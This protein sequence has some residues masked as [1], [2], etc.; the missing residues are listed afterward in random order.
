MVR[1]LRAFLDNRRGSVAITSALLM[2][3]LIGFTALGVDAGSIYTDRRK[4]QSVA[5]LAALAAVE[6]LTN[7]NTAAAATIASNKLTNSSY[8]LQ[9]GVYTPDPA[10]APANRFV[11]SSAAAANA[12]RIVLNTSTPLFFARVITGRDNFAI[13]T[14]ATAAQSSFAAFAIGSRLLT[15][16][17][18]LLNSVL[19]SLL[20]TSLSLS[21]MDYNAL[22][23]AKL[24]AFTF[25][26]ALATRLQVTSGTYDS[27]LSSNVKV[28]DIVSAM[29]DT[30]KGQYGALSPAVVALT[31]VQQS[32]QGITSK[33]NIRTMID[34][35]PYD[36]MAVG[37][38]PQASASLAAY[39]MLAAMAELA[40][41]ASQVAVA[42][43]V[44]VPGIAAATLKIKI[45]ERPQGTSWVTFG[46]TGATVHTAQTRVLLTVQLAGTGSYSLV[47]VPIYIEIA[48][49]TATLTGISCGFPDIATSTATLGVTPGLIDAWIGDVSS[50][51]FKNTSRAPNPGAAT[52]VNVAG[53]QVTARAHVSIS[54]MTATPVTFSYSDIQNQTKKTVGTTSYASS[55]VSHLIGDTT[56]GV[57][58]FGFG[59]SA[60]LISSGVRS[61]L[62]ASTTPIDQL[63][64][65][66]LQTLGVGLGQADVWMSGIRCDGGVLVL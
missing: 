3:A 66:T 4:A 62:V 43:N 47:S 29:T 6:N 52:I 19:G 18:G 46:S 56:L 55:L 5:D 65:S 54:N 9:F 25:V 42:L 16:D 23:S 7:G 63:L 12:A 28:G 32:I 10:V 44:S 20:G 37:T 11:P 48:S 50:S 24:D 61:V 45:G 38:R 31:S 1:H 36:D 58:A 13:S 59:L 51:D 41:G 34:L 17:G 53:L 60:P 21:A 2:T 26:N 8:T 14:T 22:L 57:N 27:L 40:N 64:S 15:V 30:A 39:D 33:V 35:G 49:G